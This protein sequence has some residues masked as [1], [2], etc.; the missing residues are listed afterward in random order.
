MKLT[1]QSLSLAFTSLTPI[2][3]E[4][5]NDGSSDGHHQYNQPTTDERSSGFLTMV[6]GLFK[7]GDLDLG[8]GLFPF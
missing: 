4:P 3:K 1:Y 8:N 6:V 7:F 5:S 2:I